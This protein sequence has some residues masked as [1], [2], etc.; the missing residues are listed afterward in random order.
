MMP[1]L[2]LRPV[3]LIAVGLGFVAGLIV[4]S[5]LQPARPPASG[6]GN[7]PLTITPAPGGPRVIFSTSPKPPAVSPD[8]LPAGLPAIYAFYS[9]PDMARGEAPTATWRKDGKPLAGAASRL[10]ADPERS[11]Y[12]MIVFAPPGGKLAP[13]IY[14]VAMRTPQRTFEASFVAAEAAAEILARPAPAEAVLTIAQSGTARG[15]GAQ[16]EMKQPANAFGPPDKIYFAM[17]Y[18]GAEPGTSVTVRWWGGQTELTQARQEVTL[19]AAAGW[20]H[21]W[22][23]AQSPRGLPQGGYKVTAV[24]SGRA[25]ELATAEFTIQ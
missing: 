14:E 13:G 23:Q 21:A 12:G 4:L 5:L 1:K 22:M 25:Q 16:G 8:L 9:L 2:P 18:A 11:G 10:E 24:V 20:A 19:P 7:A 6:N 17:R 3:H 15:V